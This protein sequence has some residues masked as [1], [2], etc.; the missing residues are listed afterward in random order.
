MELIPCPPPSGVLA[1]APLTA[2][3]AGADDAG[4]WQGFWGEDDDYYLRRAGA[5]GAAVRWYRLGAGAPLAAV[6]GP[7]PT[8]VREVLGGTASRGSAGRLC[9][10]GGM[11]PGSAGGSH[12]SS[13]ANGRYVLWMRPVLRR[14]VRT[15]R[16]DA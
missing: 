13:P 4:E 2:F 12:G 14:V 1:S 5:A 16:D 8:A 6:D 15:R 11:A 7:S 9:F 3:L 10:V